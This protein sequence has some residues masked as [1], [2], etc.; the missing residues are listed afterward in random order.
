MFLFLSKLIPSFLYPVGAVFALLIIAV[1]LIWRES[2]WSIAPVGLSLAI[3]FLTG[4]SWTAN[5]LINSLESQYALPA[6]STLPNAE[7]IVILGGATR[8][9]AYPRPDVDFSEA[10]DRIWYGAELY[11]QNKA[12]LIIVSGGRIDWQD[13]GNPEADDIASVLVRMNVPADKIILDKTSYNT[14]DNAV[15]VREIMKSRQINRILLV[16]SASHMPR[17]MKIFAKLGINAIAA[18]TDYQVSNI[19][20]NEPNRTW[21]AAILGLIPDSIRLEIATKAIKEYIGTW[22]Y[23]LRGWV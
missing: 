1:V 12:P 6:G 22:I 7:A 21:N 8:S 5:W 17:S 14:R 2:K 9:Q 13:S 15:N 19:E 23:A 10:G 11:R 4:N 20:L 16:T 18:P 3:L